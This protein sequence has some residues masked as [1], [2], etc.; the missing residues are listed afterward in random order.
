[1]SHTEQGAHLVVSPET[2]KPIRV[3]HPEHKAVL[4]FPSDVILVTVIA[5]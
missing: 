2:C 5:Q 1:M 4:V 3:N